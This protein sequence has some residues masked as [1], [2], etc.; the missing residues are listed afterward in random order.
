M[1]VDPSY[2]DRIL[3]R[4]NLA[5]QLLREVMAAGTLKAVVLASKLGIF[6][7]LSKTS[8]TSEEIAAR[9]KADSRGM[10]ILLDLLASSGYLRKGSG[11]IPFLHSP[12]SGCL[13]RLQCRSLTWPL[14]GTAKC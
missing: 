2:L 1:P 9:V 13:G 3:L 11:S 7:E 4:L 10:R 8:L 14:S 12:R 5:P 6:D